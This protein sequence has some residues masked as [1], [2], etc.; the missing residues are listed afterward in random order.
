MVAHHP[1]EPVPAQL[2]QRLCTVQPTHRLYHD[3][4]FQDAGAKVWLETSQAERLE[5]EG[6]VAL[7]QQPSASVTVKTARPR[8]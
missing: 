7:D 4:S 5:H 6:V 3:G 1:R 8:T 2:T